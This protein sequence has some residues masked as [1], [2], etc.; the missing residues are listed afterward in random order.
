MT[1]TPDSARPPGERKDT[2]AMHEPA[3]PSAPRANAARRP[4]AHAGDTWVA[5]QLREALHRVS[6]TLAG[7]TEEIGPPPLERERDLEPE[8]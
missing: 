4:P 1:E 3:G 7:P 8:P 5:A 2:P 6:A